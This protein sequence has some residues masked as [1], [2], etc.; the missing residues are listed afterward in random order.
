MSNLGRLMRRHPLTFTISV[1][2]TLIEV[3]LAVL[4]LLDPTKRPWAEPGLVLFGL[5]IALF[6]IPS[7]HKPLPTDEEQQAAERVITYLENKGLCY[8]DH[9]YEIPSACY[10]SAREMGEKLTEV[11]EGLPRDTDLSYDI[12][13]IRKVLHDF[14]RRL[15]VLNIHGVTTTSGLSQEQK[16]QFSNSL[17]VLRGKSGK[18]IANIATAYKVDVRGPLADMLI[19]ELRV[20]R[21]SAKSCGRE[22]ET[23]NPGPQ[24]DA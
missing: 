7:L 24:A 19:N 2:S 18:S 22:R 3:T 15:E 21:F 10:A 23:P 14:R 11:M 5:L 16:T 1:A 12:Q 13:A 20:L 9:A 17:S 4:W 8:V 6:G